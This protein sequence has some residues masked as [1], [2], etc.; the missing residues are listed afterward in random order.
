MKTFG[1]EEEDRTPD[2]CIANA[3]LS[4]LSYFPKSLPT[5]LNKRRE[6]AKLYVAR[7]GRSNGP[8]APLATLGAEGG[9]MANTDRNRVEQME[10]EYNARASIPDHPQIFARWAEQGAQAR[11]RRA[12]LIDVPYGDDE[13]ERL[14]VFPT[15][16]RSSP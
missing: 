12:G 13:G 4:Q 5:S 15:V 11:R 9:P 2:L 10:H 16:N 7:A 3:A 1:G 8:S 6:G 14:D